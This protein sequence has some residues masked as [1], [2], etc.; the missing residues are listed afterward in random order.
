MCNKLEKLQYVTE[1][2]VIV[3]HT[4]L[5]ERQRNGIYRSIKIKTNLGLFTQ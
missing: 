3:N 1:S 5:P 2:P 4:L